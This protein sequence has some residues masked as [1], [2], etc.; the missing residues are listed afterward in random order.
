MTQADS[1]V[2]SIYGSLVKIALGDYAIGE[3]HIRNAYDARKFAAVRAMC[4]GWA[5]ANGARRSGTTGPSLCFRAMETFAAYAVTVEEEVGL[6]QAYSGRPT[7]RIDGNA[8]R[9]LGRDGTSQLREWL[10]SSKGCVAAIGASLPEPTASPTYFSISGPTGAV[11]AGGSSQFIAAMF[12]VN[13]AVLRTPVL[14]SATPSLLGTLDNVGY[15]EA[16]TVNVCGTVTATAEDASASMDVCVTV[17]AVAAGVQ[18]TRT[19]P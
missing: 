5:V 11:P 16:G 18:R 2:R 6:L 9:A 1:A 17:D 4:T 3:R 13:F 10:V 7:N 19:S 14:W 12:D 8:M 15:L